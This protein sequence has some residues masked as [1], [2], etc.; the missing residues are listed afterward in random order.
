MPAMPTAS[1]SRS[2]T[3][4]PRGSDP[5]DGSEQ[6]RL[7]NEPASDF[8]PA[9]S[10][11][12]R[13]LVFVSSRDG[14]PHVY[15]MNADLSGQRRLTRGPSVDELPAWT[16]DGRIAFASRRNGNWG[17]YVTNADGSGLRDL[18][19]IPAHHVAF[20]WAPRPTS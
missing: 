19:R 20:A 3:T 18:T 17:V 6:R 8:Q 16:P 5:A 14:N 12:G 11:D 10:Q 4:S 1:S 2:R 7:T 13:R 15:V 9:W